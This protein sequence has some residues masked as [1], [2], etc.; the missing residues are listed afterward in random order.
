MQEDTPRESDDTPHPAR[1]L[2]IAAELL[3]RIALDHPGL[4]QAVW[5]LLGRVNAS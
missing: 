1:H 4:T 2:R 5:R 3:R